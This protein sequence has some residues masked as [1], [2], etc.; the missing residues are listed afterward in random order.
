M[1]DPVDVVELLPF[2]NQFGPPLHDYGPIG[3][4]GVDDERGPGILPDIPDLRCII[5]G[6]DVEIVPNQNVAYGRNKRPAP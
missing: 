6:G 5:V 4:D 2:L 3:G 1:E